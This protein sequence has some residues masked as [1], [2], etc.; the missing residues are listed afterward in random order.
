MPSQAQ[1]G[2]TDGVVRIGVI[3]F[4]W[5]GEVHSRA[6]SRL[7][8]HYPAFPLRPQL[9]AV[10]DPA[11]DDRA[12]RAMSAYGFTRHARNWREIVEAPDIDAVS[13]TGPNFIHRDAAVAAARAGKHVWVEKPVG[14]GL[15]E[16]EEVAQAIA[17]AGVACA[18]GFN[19]RHAPAV[20]QAR[21]LIAQGRL[22]RVEHVELRLLADYAAHPAGALSWRF[23][24]ARAGTGVLGDLVS[25]GI[26][27][28]RHLV[29][30]ISEL[31]GD[32][33]TFIG[34]RPRATANS[35]HFDRSDSAD[36]GVVENEDYVCA[37]L[38]FAEGARGMLLAS[39]VAV[40]E[41]CT[42]GFEIHGDRGALAWD[43]RRMGELRVC[44]DQDF[45]D[46]AW[47]TQYVAPGIGETGA[48]QP[49]SGIAMGFDD[50][51][52]IEA[53]HFL[54]SVATG[55]PHGASI[56]DAVAAARALAAM[57]TSTAQRRWVTL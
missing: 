19:Y 5:M 6:Y 22:G 52:V 53:H 8:Q 27:L 57:I 14:R 1:V 30:E 41:Q 35:S 36:L 54:S 43:F 39:R 12:V 7:H 4:G 2:I 11:A 24:N 20:V 56:A 32:D 17:A 48:F 45:Q 29:G 40:G 23:E 15:A 42:Y 55:T 44:L 34:K 46:A 21:S 16:T 9:V 10:A 37:L 49:G 13:I 47:Q 50:L 18:V 25:H 51:K 3:G 28:A 38:R 33:A 31:V 26:D